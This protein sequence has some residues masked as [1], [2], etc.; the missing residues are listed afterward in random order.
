MDE[1]LVEEI[2]KFKALVSKYKDLLTEIIES[3]KEEGE[4]VLS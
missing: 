1:E 2:S 4:D 3:L